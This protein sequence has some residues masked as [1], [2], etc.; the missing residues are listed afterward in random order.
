MLKFMGARVGR[1]CLIM[2]WVKIL[3]PC[4]LEIGDF[5]VIGRSV[6][7]YNFSP[8]SIGDCSVVSQDCFL[9]TG[10]H[11]FRKTN[12]PLVHKPIV[13]GNEVWIA[14]RAVILPGVHIADGIV[15]GAA[16][17]VSKSLPDVWSVY[18]GNPVKRI[19]SREG[20]DA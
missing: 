20:R 4:N 6:D 11:D 14:A 13:L 15:V 2:P 1:K 12:L 3:V 17:V 16:S 19:G 8:I 10:T 5:V 9:C 7:I 18:A